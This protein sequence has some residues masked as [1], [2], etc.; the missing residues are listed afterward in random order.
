MLVEKTKYL[1]DK[2]DVIDSFIYNT[3]Y[4]YAKLIKSSISP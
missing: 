1:K 2:F 4:G 3:K